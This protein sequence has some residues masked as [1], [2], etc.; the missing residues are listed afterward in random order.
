M[1]GAYTMQKL[2]AGWAGNFHE[3][4]ENIFAEHLR[5]PKPEW[6]EKL[7]AA[8]G[9]EQPSRKKSILKMFLPS[10]SGAR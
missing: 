4:V 9:E 7:F 8:D 3:F 1:L 5:S 6:L 2:C 10:D